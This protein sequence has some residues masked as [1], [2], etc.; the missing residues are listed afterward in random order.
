MHLKLD[1]ERALLQETVRAFAKEQVRPRARVWEEEQ[2]IEERVLDDAWQLGFAQLAEESGPSALTNAIVVE[3]LAWGDLGFALSAF[4]PMHAVVPLSLSAPSGERDVLPKLLASTKL[5]KATGAWVEPAV[6]Y[7]TRSMSTRAAR[8]LQG[9]TIS[10]KKTLVP[11][12][13]DSELTVVLAKSPS[14]VIEPYALHGKNVSGLS[15]SKRCDVIG[16]R[17]TPLVELAFDDTE[18]RPLFDKAGVAHARLEERALVGSAAAALGVARAA[19]E[20]ATEYARDRRAFGKAIAQ[21]QS[22]AFMLAEAAMDVEA[23]RWLTW[24]AAWSIDKHRDD[25]ESSLVEAAR[26]WRF[27]TDLAWRASD[28]CVQIFGGHGVIRDH[29]AELYFRNSRTL[30]RTPG[31]FMV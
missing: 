3:E 12:G 29:L 10:G 14:G 7:D 2:R 9:P 4:T 27:A 18:A 26:A 11:R 6:A 1:E 21:N 13:D 30:A 31:W 22:I 23:A 17:A 16:P 24:K 19:T 15:R 5:P 28:N 20:A 25:N 8:S